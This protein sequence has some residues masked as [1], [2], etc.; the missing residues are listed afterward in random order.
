MNYWWKVWQ[1][2]ESPKD[3]ENNRKLRSK[4]ATNLAITVA[5]KLN[6]LLATDLAIM[7]ATKFNIYLAN[8]LATI[9]ANYLASELNI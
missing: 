4:L 5:K 7:L 2:F 8:D 1:P 9:F 6:V 3:P